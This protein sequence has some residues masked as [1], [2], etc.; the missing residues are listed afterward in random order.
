MV[1]EYLVLRR[2]NVQLAAMLLFVA[3]LQLV[4]VAQMPLALNVQML[5]LLA[6][7]LFHHLFYEY[8]GM[9]Q[10]FTFTLFRAFFRSLVDI[11]K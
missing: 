8:S 9:S 3:R 6:N 7:V 1:V 4:L 11:N 5:H 2:E 10:V